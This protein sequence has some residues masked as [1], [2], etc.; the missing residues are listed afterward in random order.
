MVQVLCS[1]S[2]PDF[3]HFESGSG[4]YQGSPGPGPDFIMENEGPCPGPDFIHF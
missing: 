3:I 1:G 4:F 2:G